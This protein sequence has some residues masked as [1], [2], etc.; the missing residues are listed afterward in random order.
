MTVVLGS[1][2]NLDFIYFIVNKAFLGRIEFMWKLIYT[3]IVSICEG[4][5]P[6]TS[7]DADFLV[8]AIKTFGSCLK[9]ACLLW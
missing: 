6:R 5:F 8:K 4:S 3:L 2:N 7:V 1:I 9:I